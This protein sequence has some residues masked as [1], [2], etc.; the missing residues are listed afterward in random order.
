MGVLV[1]CGRALARVAVTDAADGE[2][3]TV[4]L[5]DPPGKAIRSVSL[6]F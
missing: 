2:C 5:R 6:R 3:V 1:A 4:E